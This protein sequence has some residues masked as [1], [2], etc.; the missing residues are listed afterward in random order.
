MELANKKPTIHCITNIITVNDCAN[1]LHAIGAAP[2]MAHHPCEV[3]QVAQSASALVLN[4]GATE[5]FEAMKIAMEAA[6]KT[7]KPIVIDP[8]GAGGIDFRRQMFWELIDIAAPTCI[9]GNMSEIKAIFYDSNTTIGVDA[10]SSEEISYDIYDEDLNEE[11]L[12]D[13]EIVMQLA[14]MIGCIVVASGRTDIISDGVKCAYVE[15]GTPML[16]YITG[17]GCMSSAMIGGYLGKLSAED[18]AFEAVR[19]ACECMG[20]CGEKAAGR[21]MVE[22]AGIMTFHTYLLDEIS[23]K[24]IF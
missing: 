6:D 8:V 5:D 10:N 14:K 2:V 3:A 13:E 22:G 16:T 20:K 21:T 24:Y 12:S 7:N 1:V 11:E 23:L 9:R 18:D 19:Q 15:A 4:L 17:A